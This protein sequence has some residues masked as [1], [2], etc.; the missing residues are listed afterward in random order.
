MTAH[1]PI[2]IAP[3][4]DPAEEAW[5]RLR[6]E[7]EEEF[8]HWRGRDWNN[9]EDAEIADWLALNAQPHMR[10]HERYAEALTFG[11]RRQAGLLTDEELAAIAKAHR[12]FERQER[13][14]AHRR[15][16]GA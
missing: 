11:E 5:L 2:R 4:R 8:E 9:R 1:I 12:S 14:A 7:C 3:D 13:R 16:E 6:A 15:G 10:D